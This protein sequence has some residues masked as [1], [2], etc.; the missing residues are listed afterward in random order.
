MVRL[1]CECPPPLQALFLLM[2]Y[3][4]NFVGAIPGFYSIVL[5][6]TIYLML[7]LFRGAEQV[8]QR[9]GPQK[10][11]GGGIKR[12]GRDALRDARRDGSLCGVREIR[13]HSLLLA[14]WCF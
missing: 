2:D 11:L 7:P 8:P 6:C 5:C 3:L 10:G 4:E 14:V 13:Y 12:E 1:D 9:Q